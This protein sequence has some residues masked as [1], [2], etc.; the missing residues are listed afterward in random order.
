ML[1]NRFWLMNYL[2]K[3]I[4]NIYGS[5]TVMAML[6][7]DL[8]EFRNIKYTFGHVFSDELLYQVG[9]RLSSLLRPG[10]YVAR[11]SYGE[12]AF[13]LNDIAY[14]E[15]VRHMAEQVSVSL[16]MPFVLS[17]EQR[18]SMH[19]SIGISMYPQDAE[20]GETFLKHADIAMYSARASGKE[21]YFFYQLHMSE[22]IL[23]KITIEQHMRYALEKKEFILNYQPR[24]DSQTGQLRGLEALVR[25]DH[26]ERGLLAPQYF[27]P[28]AETS[29]LIVQLGEYVIELVCQQLAIWK[30]H[31]LPLC[32]VSINVS[33]RQLHRNDL[34]ARILRHA[35]ENGIDPAL[36]EI[37]VTESCII[38]DSVTVKQQLEAFSALGMK[39]L[40][41]DFGTGYS[42][43]TQLQHYAMDLLKVDRAFTANLEN[44]DKSAALVS[45]IITM[46]H[47]LGMKVVAE[48][49]ETLAQL[50]L[51]Q[52]LACDEVQGYLISKPVSAEAI[53]ELMCR[54]TLFSEMMFVEK[55]LNLK[56]AFLV[57]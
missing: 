15:E 30:K 26:P 55:N 52:A 9:S 53:A 39:L 14:T 49:V 54:P 34:M 17:G 12:F 7:V 5:N 25:W 44:G 47:A 13:V 29:G 31:A 48:G 18:H 2:Q 16:S 22:A 27:I 32:P 4:K 45:A 3:R 37:E 46:A 1:P 19:A 8:D 41:D 38:E 6:F 57:L 56:T 23:E 21:P 24:V 11:L 33:P 36:L 43:L 50:H 10:D 20:D 28:I 35:S 42:S 40:L 51:L